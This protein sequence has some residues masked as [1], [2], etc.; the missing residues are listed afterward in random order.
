MDT[1]TKRTDF[2]KAMERQTWKLII[3][4]TVLCSAMTTAVFLIGRYVH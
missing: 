4:M 2:Q 3:W 1:E